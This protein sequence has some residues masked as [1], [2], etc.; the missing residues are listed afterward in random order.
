MDMKTKFAAAVALLALSLAGG[1]AVAQAPGGG[2]PGG[3]AGGPPRGGGFGLVPMLVESTAFPDGGIVPLEHSMYGANLLP[4]FKIT[5]GPPTAQSI[6]IIFHDLDVASGGNPDDNLHW[7]AWNIP[8]VNGVATI[9]R[10]KLPEG[11]V[12]SGMRGPAYAGPGAPNSPRY[13]HYVFEFYA[14]SSKLDIPA[15]TRD[16]NVVLA[17][18]KGKV[19]GKHSYVG[20]FRNDTNAAMGGGAPRGPG[21][22]GPPP[23]GAPRGP[24]AGGP[25]PG[26][27]PGGY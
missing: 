8:M 22:G 2:P 19:V 21:A 1:A 7:M 3:G 6:A 17:A 24:G 13:H 4:D 12:G 9:E 18:M 26:A 25:P 16:R 23:G 20:R 10:G 14:L 11:A 15:D 27:A 5:A